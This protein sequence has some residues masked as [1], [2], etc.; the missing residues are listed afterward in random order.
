[1]L[2]KALPQQRW[3]EPADDAV[4]PRDSSASLSCA[5]G[6]DR[7]CLGHS[8]AVGPMDRSP[9]D[10]RQPPAAQAHR[11]FGSPGGAFDRAERA[12]ARANR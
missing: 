9:F 1:M 5:E 10:R 4:M 12:G 7:D 2:L 3:P 8:F 11:P 6:A